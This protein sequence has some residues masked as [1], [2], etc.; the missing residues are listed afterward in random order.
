[1]SSLQ[2][3]PNPKQ[4]EGSS[5]AERNNS[6]IVLEMDSNVLLLDQDVSKSDTIPV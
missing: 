5:Q 2:S 1:M 6:T 4:S 3:F